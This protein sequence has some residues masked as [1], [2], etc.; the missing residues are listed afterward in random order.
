MSSAPSACA[1]TLSHE[2]CCGQRV[3]IDSELGWCLFLVHTIWH[4]ACLGECIKGR[5]S[6]GIFLQGY[7]LFLSFLD[8]ILLWRGVLRSLSQRCAPSE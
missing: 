7:K 8:Q 4:H 2:V 3:A 1:R 6:A 5:L